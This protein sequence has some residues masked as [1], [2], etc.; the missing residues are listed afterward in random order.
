[1]AYSK[2]TR[3]SRAFFFKNIYFKKLPF[4]VDKQNLLKVKNMK[5]KNKLKIKPVQIW[6]LEHDS[7][8][9]AK[10]KPGKGRLEV[11]LVKRKD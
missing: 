8:G 6:P 7:K 10:L 2:D 4:F 1:V 9:R 11:C 5:M 3:I